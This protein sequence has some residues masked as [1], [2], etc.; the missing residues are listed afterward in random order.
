MPAGR[1]GV[2]VPGGGKKGRKG[3][4]TGTG[5]DQLAACHFLADDL[6]MVL[7][8]LLRVTI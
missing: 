4:R 3:A 8:I 5:K 2:Y 7:G 6:C 1:S